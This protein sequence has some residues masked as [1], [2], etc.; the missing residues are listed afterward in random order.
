MN[1]ALVWLTWISS[2]F[3]GAT[4]LVFAVMKYLM[5]G[6]DPF[7]AYNH[8]LQP[9]MLA[10][11]I[12]LAPALVLALGWVWGTHAAPQLNGRGRRDTRDRRIGTRSGL[13][14]VTFGL[15]MI[16]SGYWMQVTALETL[17]L[18]MAWTHGVSGTLFVLMLV[19][20]AVVALAKSRRLDARLG[21]GESIT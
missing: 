6:E 20:H 21:R 18:T 13:A 10:A 14:N 16:L 8:P 15:V 12:L 19:G 11:H 7:S 2:T 17:R 9:W 4:G 1:R 5:Q 3:V